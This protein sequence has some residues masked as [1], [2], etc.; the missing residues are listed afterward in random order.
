M[1]GWFCYLVKIVDD[2]F[3]ILLQYLCCKG[4]NLSELAEDKCHFTMHII[5][6]YWHLSVTILKCIFLVSLDCTVWSSYTEYIVPMK[7]GGA[8]L[9]SDWSTPLNIAFQHFGTNQI[10]LCTGPNVRAW[11]SALTSCYQSHGWCQ[12]SCKFFYDVCM[13]PN[14]L[15]HHDHHGHSHSHSLLL[16]RSIWINIYKCFIKE[17]NIMHWM[18]MYNVKNDRWLNVNF[19]SF[20]LTILDRN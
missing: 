3:T 6:K 1:D 15:Q 18:I 17:E 14:N 8:K 11:Q 13:T 5:T 10:I 12:H 19:F 4:Y 7:R 9:A 2:L 20:F 16:Y